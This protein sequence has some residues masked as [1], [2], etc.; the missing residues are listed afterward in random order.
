MKFVLLVVWFALPQ[1]QNHA[2]FTN[3]AARQPLGIAMQEF[4]D[5][6]ACEAQAKRLAGP[7]VDARCAPKSSS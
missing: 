2:D 1:Q 6:Q 3:V 5:E 4:D 7:Y